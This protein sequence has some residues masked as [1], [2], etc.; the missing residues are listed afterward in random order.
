MKWCGILTI[1]GGAL[2]CLLAPVMSV[3]YYQSY[4]IPAETPPFWFNAVKPFV[5]FLYSFADAKTAYEAYGKLFA[6]VYLLFLPGFFA[7]HS[8]QEKS[9]SRLERYSFIFLTIVLVVCFFGVSG[10]YW[11][12]KQ[13]WTLELLGMLLLQ[14]SATL[15]GIALVRLKTF[16]FS[17]V[18]LLL[19]SIPFCVISFM[20]L[21]QIP[22][23]PTLPFALASI[24]FG[25]FILSKSKTREN[26][27]VTAFAVLISKI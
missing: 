26:A 27:K 9:K 11:G 5:S 23:A 2:A 16:P 22:S 20:L 25:L 13:G 7:I 1:V 12:I 10:D 21:K 6:V 24:V 14:I 17:S 15:Y 3:G 18:V 19:G 8:I 4:A